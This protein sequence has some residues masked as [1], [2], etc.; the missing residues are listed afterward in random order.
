MSIKLCL[1][2]LSVSKFK[3]LSVLKAFHLKPLIMFWLPNLFSFTQLSCFKTKIRIGVKTILQSLLTKCKMN[4][5]EDNTVLRS[6]HLSV[7]CNK[8]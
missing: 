4:I 5:K 6:K 8:V 2:K 1:G 7:P 3:S